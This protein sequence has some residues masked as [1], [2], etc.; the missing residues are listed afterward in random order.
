[1]T[2][3][4]GL[5]C[6]VVQVSIALQ[7]HSQPLAAAA[8][9]APGESS[10]A[11]L[12]PALADLA[13]E[14][15]VVQAVSG[16]YRPGDGGGGWFVWREGE[17]REENR[18][19]VWGSGS[20]RWLRM[21]ESEFVLYSKWFGV[22][23]DGVMDDTAAVQHFV[24]Q[25]GSN[26]SKL[27]FATGTYLLSDTIYIDGG[28][29][30]PC[31][32]VALQ[33]ETWNNNANYEG[34]SAKFYWTG[35]SATKPMFWFRGFD[36][37]VSG[38]SFEPAGTKHVLC[39]IALTGFAF[40][41]GTSHYSE[42]LVFA[43]QLR[44]EGCT[45]ST[46]GQT[47]ANRSMKYGVAIGGTSEMGWQGTNLENCEINRCY[48]SGCTQGGILVHGGQAI[49]TRVVKC[50]FYGWDGPL[51]GQV[52]NSKGGA[53]IINDSSST[54]MQVYDC[55]YQSLGQ[56]FRV[57]YPFQ[58]TVT[59]GE[60]E[61]SHCMLWQPSGSWDTYGPGYAF[62]DLRVVSGRIGIPSADGVM[63]DGTPEYIR[64]YS[65]C[66]LSL[67]NITFVSEVNEAY[68]DLLEDGGTVF[69]IG[70]HMGSIVTCKNVLFPNSNPFSSYE[71][72][73]E[74]F[75]KGGVWLEGCKWGLDSSAHH[76]PG[77]GPMEDRRGS[78]NPPGVVRL[79]GEETT[80]TVRLP[81]DQYDS[82]YNVR[83]TLTGSSPTAVL[84][85]ATVE[86]VSRHSFVVRVAQAPGEEESV[87][88]RWEI[89]K[90]AQQ[91]RQQL[92]G[93]PLVR[94]APGLLL[95]PEYATETR[96][97]LYSAARNKY[98]QGRMTTAYP[99][100][101]IATSSTL[102]NRPVLV[103][104]GLNRLY[105]GGWSEFPVE[106]HSILL[107]ANVLGTGVPISLP[108]QGH[109]GTGTALHFTGT[110]LRAE[111]LGDPANHATTAFATGPA[112]VLATFST[113]HARLY[114][115][116]TDPVAE[117]LVEVG[118]VTFPPD[119]ETIPSLSVYLGGSGFYIMPPFT[120]A[121][122][123]EQN[124]FSGE[125]AEVAVWPRLLSEEEIGS[126][127]RSRSR[128]YAVPLT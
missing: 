76:P 113:S 92:A 1:M 62:R 53:A 38:L 21:G 86:S 94:S 72:G 89:E 36:H 67:E 119:Q 99:A 95:G 52:A 17:T 123:A 87:V 117:S 26:R 64:N 96:E 108:W 59:G 115:N 46:S 51:N 37:S 19:T 24:D 101:A 75:C 125:I 31:N 103:F 8:P 20:G 88:Y 45:F 63:G 74:D 81:F 44:V 54:T 65:G 83:L 97:V 40:P 28:H 47:L 116:S 105:N 56:W 39:A 11:I 104:P 70:C 61:H 90:T 106:G 120:A 29:N 43:S 16:Y 48:F 107:V 98:A 93:D 9:P 122:A 127:L 69:T 58:L 2:P 33:A 100:V 34:G 15:G 118:N 30:R 82:A 22:V 102:N 3:R 55:D 121:S 112:L 6:Y 126:L 124:F 5:G 79:E 78:W 13:G 84:S 60:S 111:R 41:V 71:I 73:W 42:G 10:P 57:L 50:N 110:E 68:P 66:P 7:E 27:V 77:Y 4:P 49:N 23:G 32:A 18:G 12:A 114:L 109:A 14:D 80:A 25:A 35:D 128:K 85:P 91:D